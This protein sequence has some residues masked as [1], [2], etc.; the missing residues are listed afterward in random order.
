MEQFIKMTCKECGKEE[1]I[2]VELGGPYATGWLLLKYHTGFRASDK[3]K[4]FCSL[5]C[6]NKWSKDAIKKGERP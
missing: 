1:L 2:P 4:W 3:D 5:E 6:V